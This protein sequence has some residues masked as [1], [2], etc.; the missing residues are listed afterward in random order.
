MK[1]LT[2]TPGLFGLLIMLTVGW[3]GLQGAAIAADCDPPPSGI[4][5]WWPGE[6]NANDIIG[7]NN[8]VLDGGVA[9]APGEVGQAFSF[10]GTSGYVFVPA[11]S[12][13][14][15]GLGSG[16]TVE[17]WIETPTTNDSQIIVEWQSA[18][19]TGGVHMQTGTGSG[20]N[21]S[22]G[23]LYANLMDTSGGSHMIWSSPG[24]LVANQF[25]HI[26][27]TYDE[28]SGLGTLYVNGS[29][30]AQS[31]WACL[32]RRRAMIFIWECGW[33]VRSSIRDCWMKS[34]FTTVPWLPTKLPP[35]TKPAAQ[36][37]VQ[38]RRRR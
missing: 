1:I 2:R 27:L 37:N 29:V 18:L 20:G 31:V 11:S 15:V 28:T 26:A 5:A 33:A 32:R 22:A 9:Y 6:G 3:P 21:P 34:V 36:A 13:L 8:G 24:V 25:Q 23:A 4:V 19:V 38:R 12:D 10:A 17:G 14:N 16:L 30:V 7:T 35:F